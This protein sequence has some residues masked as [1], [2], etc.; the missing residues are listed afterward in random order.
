MSIEVCS[1][2][3]TGVTLTYLMARSNFVTLFFSI[4]KSENSVFFSE[5]IAASDLKGART[6][7]LIE[8]MK[9]C[10]Y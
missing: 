10:E 9:I 5:T 3:D 6:N 4:G 2:D 8:Y 7:H 1:N